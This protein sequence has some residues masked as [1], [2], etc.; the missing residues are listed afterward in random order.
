MQQQKNCAFY[1]VFTEMLQPGCLELSQL[2]VSFVMEFM[3]RGLEPE[4]EE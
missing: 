1:V 3:K 4:A 2:R